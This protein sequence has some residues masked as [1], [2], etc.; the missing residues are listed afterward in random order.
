MD[1]RVYTGSITRVTSE[2]VYLASS[3]RG[4]SGDG[5]K[6]SELATSAV[7]SAK[8]DKGEEVFFFAPLA[9]PLAAIVGLTIIGTAPYWG[10]PRP[11]YGG[12]WYW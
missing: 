10:R 3:G 9:I 11:Y 5:K 8:Q 7:G 12:G 1:G 2:H 6:G 4:I